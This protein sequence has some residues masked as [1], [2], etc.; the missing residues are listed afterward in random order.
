MN[1]VPKPKAV[2]MRR[3]EIFSVSQAAHYAKRT[4]KT[5]RGWV[6]NDGIGRQAKKGGPIEIS[7][8]ALLMV[9]QNDEVALELLRNGERSHP[10]V[11]RYIREIGV[12]E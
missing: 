6:K 1:S 2:L 5:I 8:I 12:P 3:D 10:D 9:L 11:L 4:E 7:R